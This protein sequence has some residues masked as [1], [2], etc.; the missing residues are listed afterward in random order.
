MIALND[1]QK[2]HKIIIHDFLSEM[3]SRTNSFV[4]KGGTALMECYGLSLIHI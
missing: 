3:N 4:L 2:Q 1:W